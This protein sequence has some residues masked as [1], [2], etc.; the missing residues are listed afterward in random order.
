MILLNVNVAVPASTGDITVINKDCC[1]VSDRYCECWSIHTLL[2]PREGR[3]ATGKRTALGGR[4]SLSESLAM[5]TKK[6]MLTHHLQCVAGCPRVL[7]RSGRCS[8]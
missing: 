2:G 1:F 4:D 7:V 8:S 3:K 5:G 6:Q